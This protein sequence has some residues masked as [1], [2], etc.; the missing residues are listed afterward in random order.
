MVKKYCQLFSLFLLQYLN[1]CE[2]F[3]LDRQ[4]DFFYDWQRAMTNM[5]RDLAANNSTE[6]QKIVEDLKAGIASGRF[7]PG[8]RLVEIHL[9]NVLGVTRGKIREAL[10]KL[11]Q[12]GFVEIIPNVGAR[13]AEF[14]Q[15]D[16]EHIYDLMSVVEGLAVRVDHSLFDG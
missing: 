9:S 12:D 4:G 8:Q 2:Q 7:K 6:R 3:S 1:Y 15:K 5:K 10:R 13:V 11:E 14:S 16:I